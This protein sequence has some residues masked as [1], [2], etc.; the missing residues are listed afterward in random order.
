MTGL[1]RTAF[2]R[3]GG[4]VTALNVKIIATRSRIMTQMNARLMVFN[5]FL[6]MCSR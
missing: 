6:I 5:K 2:F 1:L 4:D 3:R